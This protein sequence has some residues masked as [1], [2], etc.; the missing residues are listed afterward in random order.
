[1]KYRPTVTAT[2]RYTGCRAGTEVAQLDVGISRD[3]VSQ[4]RGFE[5]VLFSPGKSAEATFPLTRRNLSTWD[6]EPT[7]GF[8]EEST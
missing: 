4:L 8:A 2:V 1:M 3:P 7:V 6:V 5:N